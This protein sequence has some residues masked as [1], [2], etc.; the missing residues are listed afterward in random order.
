M[1]YIKRFL[2]FLVSCAFTM[3]VAFAVAYPN[4]FDNGLGYSVIACGVTS[5]S[6]TSKEA[7]GWPFTYQR[8]DEHLQYRAGCRRY[9]C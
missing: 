2:F 3:P 9:L 6:E 8:E 4:I 5:S 1:H 7:F